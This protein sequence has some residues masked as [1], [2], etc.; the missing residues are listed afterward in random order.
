MARVQV[1]YD[2]RKIIMVI[3]GVPV[4]DPADEEN[5]L[6]VQYS[7][8]R[9]TIQTGMYGDAAFEILVAK[10]GVF[11]VMLKAKS[12]TNAQ[13]GILMN[14]SAQFRVQLLNK[15][16][17][18]ETASCQACMVQTPPSLGGGISAANR[19]WVIGGGEINMI[20]DGHRLALPLG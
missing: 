4:L 18:V 16:T 20:F 1:P 14:A 3:N 13:L 8:D 9:V 12:P 11:N 15:N 2:P 7:S 5:A 17:N 6:T 10:N 19:P